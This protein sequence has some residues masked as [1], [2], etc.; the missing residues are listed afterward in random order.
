MQPFLVK[1]GIIAIEVLFLEGHVVNYQAEALGF[2][3]YFVT[4]R[5]WK[6]KNSNVFVKITFECFFF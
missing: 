1:D 4:L 6:K 5:F 2:A 3:V